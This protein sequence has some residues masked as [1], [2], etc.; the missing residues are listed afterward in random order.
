MPFLRRAKKSILVF[1]LLFLTPSGVFAQ[2]TPEPQPGTQGEVSPLEPQSEPPEA[3]YESELN[4]EELRQRITGEA[5]GEIMAFSLGDSNVSL[6]MTGSWKGELQGNA[7]FSVSPFGTSFAAPETPL[8]FKQEVDL[9]VSLWI[10]DRWFV[11]ANFL[12][13]YTK[14][15]YRAGYQGMPGEFLKYAG[16]GNTGLDFPSF[17]YLDLGGDSPSSF[18]IYSR[19]GTDNLNV[20]ALFRYDAASREERFFS[21]GRERVYSYASVEN[22][23]RGISFVLPDENIDSEITVYI[24]DE[25]G[26]VRDSKGRRWRIALPSEYAASKARGLLELT[27]RP[28]GMVAVAYSKGVNSQPWNASM[29]NYGTTGFLHTVQQWFGSINL[30]N[31]PQSG[32]GKGTNARPGEVEFGSIHALVIREPGTFSPFE[33]RSLYASPSSASQQADLVSLSSGNGI[34]GFELV[35]LDTNAS[36]S[37]SPLSDDAVQYAASAGRRGVYEL[38][39]QGNSS[40]RDPKLLWPLAAEYP[41]IY[42]PSSGVFTGDITIRFTNFNNKSGY[43]IGTDAVPGSIQVWR[44]GIQAANFYYN[45]ASGEVTISGPVGY[46]ENIRITYLK[47]SDEARL[48]SIAAGLGIVYSGEENPFSAQ[49]AIGLRMN[50]AGKDS[51][52]EDDLDSAGTVGIGAKAGWD[53]DFFKANVTA[54]FAFVQTDTTGLYR[55]AGME[56]NEAVLALPPVLSFVSHPPSSDHTLTHNNRADLIYRNYSNNNAFDAGLLFI[57]SDVPVVSGI[58]KPYP[59]RDSQ[60]GDTQVM[61]AEFSLNGDE[62]TGFQVPLNNYAGLLS[63]AGE[64]EIP[65]RFYGFSGTA[66]GLKLIVQIGALSGENIEYEEN[67]EL[68]WEEELFPSSGT[69]NTNA[70]IKKFILTEENRLQLADAKYMCIIAV[71]TSGADISGRVLIAPPIVRGASF[72]AVIREN[73]RV[74]P[75]PDFLSALNRVRAVETI[76]TGANKLEYAYGDLIKRLHPQSQTNRVL[77]IDW[78][79]MDDGV[80]A[81]VDGR[82]G[83]L[84]LS[85]YNELSFFVKGPEPKDP[86]KPIVGSLSF[87]VA[88]GPDSI[89]DSQLSAHIPLS[90]FTAGQWSKVTIRYQGDNKGVFV[91]GNKVDDV[92]YR[93]LSSQNDNSFRRSDYIAVFINPA[94]ELSKLEDGTISIDEIILEDSVTVFRMNAGAGVEYSRPGTFLSAGGIPVLADFFVTGAIESEILTEGGKSDSRAYGSVIGRTGAEIS[95]FG[96]KVTGNFSFSAAENMFL[97]SADHKISK[98]IGSF[99]IEE[100]FF[101]SVAEKSA[102]HNINMSYSSD[103]YAKF[104]ADA[105][106]EFSL[107][108]QKWNI[109]AGYN[110]QKDY[111]PSAALSFEALWTGKNQ[112]APDGYAKLWAESWQPLVPDLGEGAGLRKTKTQIVITQRSKPVGAVA[113]IEGSSNFSGAN[114]LTVLEYSTLLDVPVIINRLSLNFSAG[115]NFKRRLY[116]YGNNALDDGVKFFESV[117]DSL[118]VW[119]VFPGYSLFAP[120]L[121]DAFKRG[122]DASPS[123]GLAQ[124]SALTDHF[125]VNAVLPNIYNLASFIVPSKAALR[126]E[127]ALE[128]KYDTRVDMFKLNGSLVFQSINMFGALGYRPLFKFYQT[129]EYS[130]SLEASVIIPVNEEVSWRIQ[131]VIG[132]GFRGFS[133]GNLNLVNSLTL[134]SGGYWLESFSADWT[135][136]TERN[137]LSVFYDWAAGAAAKQSSWLALSSLLSQDYEQMRIISIDLAFDKKTDYLRWTITVGH[138]EIVRILGRL[139]FSTFIKIRCS[140]DFQS[141]VF[142]FDALLGAALRISF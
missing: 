35:L 6:F 97:W 49:A 76:E 46:N 121:A 134:N 38:L 106:Y 87:I 125:G 29:G 55:A 18:G 5:P 52:T 40:R 33:K 120:E 64:I 112:F 71:N 93:P 119:T 82:V 21:G 77:E 140:Q 126:L 99:Y 107:L 28:S 127:R 23:L 79:D 104:A 63:R 73:D 85:N 101:A 42:L 43:Y 135:I 137:L 45:S 103:F 7:G 109:G 37:D 88:S 110:S 4:I 32:N 15:T 62:W 69:I 26:D 78:E 139:N 67:I 20:H 17:P 44:S 117:N 53:F 142:I 122:L 3:E 50:L 138:E 113:V 141:K 86:L 133:G 56:G 118:S 108:N 124:Y 30:E 95:I 19:F 91:N 96:I 41:E 68:V 11:E 66:N 105:L 114:S 70:Q 47:L 31:Y 83:E 128:Q 89:S 90:A 129:D 9:G 115:R 102:R 54:G 60:L 8:L 25:K 36:F 74:S 13:D 100:S 59:A 57:E 111:I 84:P 72:R 22:S 12:D 94:D 116:F 92:R 75:S 48:G 58:N 130:H 16:I 80:S 14:N 10:N 136:P 51:F 24:E 2:N 39:P 1:L 81:G 98:S 61:V 132:A 34:G 123:A 65:F 27:V 131:S